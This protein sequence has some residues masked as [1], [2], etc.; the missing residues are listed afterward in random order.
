APLPRPPQPIKATLT[1][2]SLAAW[3][4]RAMKALVAAT[5]AAAAALVFR[6][7][8]RVESALDMM[9]PDVRGDYLPGT[10]AGLISPRRSRSRSLSRVVMGSSEFQNFFF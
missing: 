7:S 1:V 10:G 9:S 6:K 2:S 5:V 3:A 8:R 4:E